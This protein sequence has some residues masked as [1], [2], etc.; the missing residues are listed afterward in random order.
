M[1]AT[2]IGINRPDSCG[3]IVGGRDSLSNGKGSDNTPPFYED[4]MKI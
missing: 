2:D 3:Q 4:L 1:L